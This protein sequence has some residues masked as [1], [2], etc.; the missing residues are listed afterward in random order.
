MSDN[1]LS[2]LHQQ[3]EIM[4]ILP[5]NTELRWRSANSA[6][7]WRCI[8]DWMAAEAIRADI[9]HKPFELQDDLRCLSDVAYQHY[10]NCLPY[11]SD[12]DYEARN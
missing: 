7:Q 3:R 6:T 5:E 1:E 11:R 8:A 4:T 12:F 2:T 10:L 9:N